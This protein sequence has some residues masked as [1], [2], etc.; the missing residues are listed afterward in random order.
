MKGYEI[1]H[2]MTLKFPTSRLPKGG[3]LVFQQLGT[4]HAGLPI[5]SGTKYIAQ[6]G[7]LRRQPEGF[8]KPAVFRL[9]PGLKNY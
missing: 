1:N 7:L 2:I 3:M 5:D 9:G 4:L 8:L 6:T